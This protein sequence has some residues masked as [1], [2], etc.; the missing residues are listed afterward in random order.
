MPNPVEINSFT[1]LID[2]IYL[3]SAIRYGI[4]FETFWNLNPKYMNMYQKDYMDKQKEKIDN[5][6]VSAWLNGMYFID[7][8]QVG[9]NPKKAKY[10]KSPIDVYGAEKKA[11]PI[12]ASK[13]F[14]DWANAWNKKFEN[15]NAI[16]DSSDFSESNESME[17]YNNDHETIQ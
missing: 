5:L 10:P 16:S 15:K 11:N 3:P 9:L 13:R 2:K 8:I 14:E 17:N 7:S 12:V 6:N 4:P 1:D